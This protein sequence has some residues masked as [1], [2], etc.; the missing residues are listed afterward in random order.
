MADKNEHGKRIPT[1]EE[2][3]K[4]RK[5]ILEECLKDSLREAEHWRERLGQRTFASPQ[6]AE[7]AEGLFPTID[8]L[9]AGMDGERKTKKDILSGG[10]L[11]EKLRLYYAVTN[12][13]DYF[14]YKGRKLSKAE[15]GMIQDAIKT[16]E[17]L[18]AADSSQR[19]YTLLLAYGREMDAYF[20]L[21]QSS[22]ASL[23]IIL[24]KWDSYEREA[25]CLSEIYK[26]IK[27]TEGE[28]G[29]LSFAYH[30]TKDKDTL[31]KIEQAQLRFDPGADQPIYLD[32]D[33]RFYK[34]ATM[35]SER[36]TKA[37]ADFKAY[38][39]TA[40]KFIQDSVTKYVPISVKMAIDNAKRE[41]YTRYLVKNRVYFRSELNIRKANGET[42]TQEEERRALIPDY[43]E[44]EPTPEILADVKDY[45]ETA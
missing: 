1:P 8:E 5:E 32:V 3:E 2:E 10:T 6:T 40:E 4:A 11:V 22:F 35:T 45:F 36:A 41:S 33:R 25:L 24:N 44:V 18:K 31:Y 19:E 38:A 39:V 43:L 13:M 26:K 16:D 28:D 7:E 20:K 15:L 27:S 9:A 17:D 29:A 42:I 14:D 34:I 37:L 30:I 21:F 12:S 23:A